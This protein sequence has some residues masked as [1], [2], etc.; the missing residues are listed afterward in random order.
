MLGFNV[1]ELH[2][3]SCDYPVQCDKQV[4]VIKSGFDGKPIKS[5]LLRLPESLTDASKK[6]VYYL[7][8]R[9]VN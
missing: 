6:P 7:V 2:I 3:L 5:R 8:I 9:R 1:Q 4:A